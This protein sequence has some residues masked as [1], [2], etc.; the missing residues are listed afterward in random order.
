MKNFTIQKVNADGTVE[1]TFDVDAKP[2]VLSGMMVTDKDTLIDQITQ[3][4]EAYEA[5]LGIVAPQAIPNN[6]KNLEGKKNGFKR[7]ALNP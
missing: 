5:G 6:V 2:Q 3:Y 7:L 1:V 4:G